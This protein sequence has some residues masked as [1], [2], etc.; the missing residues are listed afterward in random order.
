M[1]KRY[2]WLGATRKRAVRD[3]AS[4]CFDAWLRDWCLQYEVCKAAVE[5]IPLAAC[6]SEAH[7]IWVVEVADGCLLTSLDRSR[8]DALGGRLALAEAEHTDGMAAELACA[9]V[10]DLAVRL[11]VRAGHPHASPIT[12]GDAWPD[13]ILHPVWG[14]LVLQISFDGF[15]LL[16][17]MDRAMV[18]VICPERARVPG[19]LS[20]R[21]KSIESIPVTLSAVLDF[22]SVNARDLAGLRAGEV[23]VSERT[24][25]QP[26]A[27]RAGSCDVFDANLARADRH[28][29]IVVAAPPTGENS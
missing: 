5:E 23:L 12:S 3:I 28:L 19:P 27:L 17:G 16:V 29:A 21:T 22:G 13:S 14:G 26:I 11:A 9:A 2:A 25:G 8:L 1:S 20:T 18:N 24:V 10:R 15:E 6:S 7:V 4:S